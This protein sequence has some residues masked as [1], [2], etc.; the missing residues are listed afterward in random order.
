[1]N[2][3]LG[4]HWSDP[5]AI[6]K[7]THYNKLKILRS[8]F[9]KSMKTP[10]HI[11]DETHATDTHLGAVHIWKSDLSKGRKGIILCVCVC[12]CTHV[13]PKANKL[14]APLDYRTGSRVLFLFAG[15]ELPERTGLDPIKK[16][17]SHQFETRNC[18][19]SVSHI[20]GAIEN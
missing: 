8:I 11:W 3:I 2:N 9:E 18:I 17:W 16:I 5:T 14:K 15:G 13:Y 20:P 7:S 4:T 12:V 6:K 10:T 19:K 1:M